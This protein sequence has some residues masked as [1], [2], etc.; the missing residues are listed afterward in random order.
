MG[1]PQRFTVCALLSV[2]AILLALL[3][4]VVLS[5]EAVLLAIIHFPFHLSSFIFLSSFLHLFSPAHVPPFSKL[6]LPSLNGSAVPH[7]LIITTSL[8]WYR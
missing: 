1:F 4:T 3:P 6:S 5:Q 7:L 8:W 2:G